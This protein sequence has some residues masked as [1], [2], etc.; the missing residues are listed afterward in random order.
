[1][2]KVRFEPVTFDQIHGWTKDD[3]L[4]ALKAFLKS[5][6]RVIAAARA[7]NLAGKIATPPA[8]LAACADA[9]AAK[10]ITTPA[11]ARKLFDSMANTL[12]D[13]LCRRAREV[14]GSG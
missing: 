4:A 12:V 9:S 10:G 8:L 2:D 6:D 5:C 14:Y 11:A 1:M 13:A 3:H 7:G